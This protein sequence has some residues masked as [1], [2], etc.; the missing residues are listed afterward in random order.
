MSISFDN[1]MPIPTPNN[2]EA[3]NQET[4]FPLISPM[5]FLF[6]SCTLMLALEAAD[7]KKQMF[8]PALAT[9]DNKRK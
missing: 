3:V 8:F 4:L 6:E 5:L 9:E 7:N 1:P 2:V